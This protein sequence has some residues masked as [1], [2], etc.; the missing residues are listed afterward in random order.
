MITTT[1]RS[2]ARLCAG[3]APTTNSQRVASLYLWGFFR[4][5]CHGANPDGDSTR[6]QFLD[7]TLPTDHSFSPGCGSTPC[8]PHA[9][10]PYFPCSARS[11]QD[12]IGF[13]APQAQAPADRS[14]Y[15]GAEGMDAGDDRRVAPLRWTQTFTCLPSIQ[16]VSAFQ[17][18]ALHR[19]PAGREVIAPIPANIC[20]KTLG[21]G[22]RDLTITKCIVSAD[23][24]APKY[25]SSPQHESR[26]HQAQRGR[27]WIPYHGQPSGIP[28]HNQCRLM[29]KTPGTAMYHDDQAALPPP[30]PIAWAAAVS[31]TCSTTP[32]SKK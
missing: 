1:G 11:R 32:T 14:R 30:T 2:L 21:P 24:M 26:G 13:H 23:R 31:K 28:G 18:C 6:F 20:S 22:A 27:G 8:P 17:Y 16:W 4:Q 5:S 25:L 10:D 19:K 3:S 15:S 29:T 12:P 7:Q 9:C